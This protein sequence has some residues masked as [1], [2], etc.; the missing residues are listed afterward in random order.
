MLKNN[1]ISLRNNRICIY[2]SD[3]NA[4]LVAFGAFI[5]FVLIGAST[6]SNKS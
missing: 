5:M 2:L 1:N 3:D 6:Y 4:K